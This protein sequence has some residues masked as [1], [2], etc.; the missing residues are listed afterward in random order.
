MQEA[1]GT[2]EEL[3]E[4]Y[5]NLCLSLRLEQADKDLGFERGKNFADL[6]NYIS[7]HLVGK[8][9]ED[10]RK[11]G[12][13]MLV[14]ELDTSKTRHR[15]HELLIGRPGTG[16]T[17]MMLWW[18]EKLQGILINGEFVSKAGLTGDAR[19]KNVT[20][21]LLSEYNG[22][23]VLIDEL[24]KMNLVDQN[25]LL[26]SMEEGQYFIVKGKH[27]EACVA[28]IRV[29]GSTNDLS[30]I[31]RPLLDRF[32]FVYHCKTST[33]TERAENVSRITKSFFGDSEA[34]HVH[35]LKGYLSWVGD[36]NPTRLPSDVDAIDHL[37]EKYI[38]DRREIEMESVSYRSLEYSILRIA[39]GI[40][41]LQKKNVTDKEVMSAIIFKDRILRWLYPEGDNSG[42]K[43]K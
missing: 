29:I 2:T 43:H 38:V 7:P 10:I 18:R 37:I 12:L 8:E 33:R 24:D 23:F 30:K 39:W 26:Q 1:D 20:K 22:N 28:E 11:S 36:Y 40:A 9:W 35:Y 31:Q 4:Q 3:K 13:L 25:S 19:G 32:D 6:A 15:M 16:K 41:K 17:E 34:E 5:T 21:G 42:K 14:S 27:R